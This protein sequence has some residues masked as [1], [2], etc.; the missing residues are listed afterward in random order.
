M[1]AKRLTLTFIFVIAGLS[2]VGLIVSKER[3]DLQLVQNPPMTTTVSL[4]GTSMQDFVIENFAA[5][6]APAGTDQNEYLIFGNL[7]ISPSSVDLSPKLDAFLGRWEGYSYSPPVKKDWKFVLVVQEITAQGGKAYFW[8]GTNLQYPTWVKEVRFNVV[9][10]DVPSIAWEDF[11][12]DRRIVCTFSFDPAAGLLRG[13][14][15]VPKYGRMEPIELGHDRSFH[16]YKDYPKYLAGK[17]I[18]PQEYRDSWLTNFYGSGFLLYLPDGYEDDPQ[19]LWPLIFFLHGAGDR[20]ANVFLLAKASPLMMIRE[21]GPL[22]FIIVA[23]LLN[24]SQYYASFP[25]NYMDG[26]LEQVLEDYRVDRQRIYVTGLSIGGEATY[27]FA[28]HRPDMFAAIAPLAA[29]LYSSPSMESIKDLPVWAIHGADD[30][31]VPLSLAQKP[32]DL[33]KQAGGN[34]QFTILENHDHDVWTDTY[35]DPQFYDWFL[36]HKRP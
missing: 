31:I 33:L 6:H 17:R 23:P 29:F 28:L 16:V 3:S 27:R 19:Q 30:T 14:L 25:E 36:Q 10:G 13:W 11:E 7:P 12:G 1:K 26:V 22:P 20:G 18:Y 24:A 15:D 34:V 2:V 4:E 21:K 9:G 8:G 32:V 35:T 5:V